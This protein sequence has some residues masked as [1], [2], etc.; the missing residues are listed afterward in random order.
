MD[1]D[2]GLRLGVEQRLRPAGLRAGLVVR[3]GP[4]G[5]QPVGV[6][7]VGL[8]GGARWWT[9]WKRARPSGV[10][11]PLAEQP[12]GARVVG[13]VVPGGGAGP[14]HAALGLDALVGDARVVGLPARRGPAQL[15]EDGL[16]VV[17]E[18]LPAPEPCRR[19]RRAPPGRVRTPPGARA[20]RRRRS[21]RPSRLVIV[22]SSSA[23]W[24]Q[25]R[26]TSASAAVSERKRSETAR[27]SV[28][29][30]RSRTW[31]ARGAL[32]ATLEAM[33]SSARTPPSVP[34]RSSIS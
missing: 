4:A 8:L 34:S 23:H 19:G 1:L 28:S 24:A 17:G 3:P 22:P 26:T 32:T 27:K 29:A 7:A 6:V 11:K 30:S 2:G 18:E 16:G 12:R 13:L 15:V 10:A 31:S 21:T 14:E 20:A 33:T 5:G 9:T 25:G